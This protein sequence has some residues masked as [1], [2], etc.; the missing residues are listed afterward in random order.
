MFVFKKARI[1]TKV[2]DYR[3]TELSEYRVPLAII[4]MQQSVLFESQIGS[5]FY[6]AYCKVSSDFILG[7]LQKPQDNQN[8]IRDVIQDHKKLAGNNLEGSDLQKA[9]ISCLPWK[10]RDQIH[11]LYVCVPL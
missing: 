8:C 11:N 2:T 6:N 9:Y 3:Y 10:L 1:Q 5:F 4:P 7:G